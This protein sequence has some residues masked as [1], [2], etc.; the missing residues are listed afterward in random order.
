MGWLDKISDTTLIIGVFVILIVVSA[1]GI[2]NKAYYSND[3]K[4]PRAKN[5]YLNTKYKLYLN[6]KVD[7]EWVNKVFG[8]MN[9][10][11]A[12]IT[13][14]VMLITKNSTVGIIFYVASMVIGNLIVNK[15]VINKYSK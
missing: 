15:I 12:A 14:V 6:R 8:I 2:V 5:H 10:V 11:C 9:I 13:P 3:I 7:L 1:F 4:S